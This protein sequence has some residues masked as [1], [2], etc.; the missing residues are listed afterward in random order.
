VKLDRILISR[1]KY[2]GDIVLTTPII[3]SVRETYP[4]AHIAYLGDKSAVTLL[5]NN[6]HLSEIIPYDFSKPDF[7]EQPRVAFVLRRRKFDAFIDLFSNPRSAMLAR[8]SG[9]PVRIGKDSKGRGAL[10]THRIPDPPTLLT[11]VEYHYRYVEP[12]GV[13]PLS[14]QT[15]IFLT[16][17]E[18]REA[19]RYL[20]WQDLDAERPIIGIH[21]G[22]TWPAKIWP[23]EYF[24]DLID[25]LHAKLHAHVVIT[26]GPNDAELV[27]AVAARA[28]GSV[29]VLPVM[30]LRPLAAILSRLNAYIANDTGVMHIAVGVG[31]RTIGLFGPGEER[32][33]FPYGPPYYPA[34]PGH[35]ALR[36]DVPCHPCHLNVCNREGDGYMECMKLLKPR[37]VIAALSRTA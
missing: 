10:F 14:W 15:E 34:S 21:P 26:Q 23:K 35:T 16:E 7:Y 31:T 12:I 36:R 32:S 13:K 2:I 22:A 19:K 33:W 20:N 8:L 30:H 37:D 24:A 5:E 4:N 1:L 9:A 28:V 25:L 18:K 17:P 6:P 3:R 11:A 29:T 27:A